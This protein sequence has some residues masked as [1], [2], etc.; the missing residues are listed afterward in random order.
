M[1]ATFEAIPENAKAA[2]DF[3]RDCMLAARLPTDSGV[4][5]DI[6]L[7]L[8]SELVTNAIIHAQSIFE[9]WVE[10]IPP[11][12]RIGVDDASPTRPAPGKAARTDTSGRGL[13]MVEALSWG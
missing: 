3:V 6:A 11:C 12:V 7:L 10:W 13:A 1:R 2:R 5:Q 4:D 9:V 8:T